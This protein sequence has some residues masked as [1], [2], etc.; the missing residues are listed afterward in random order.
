[1]S[2]LFHPERPGGK[3]GP[4]SLSLND[5]LLPLFFSLLTATSLTL[6]L[7]ALTYEPAVVICMYTYITVPI[8]LQVLV[9]Q[10]V[11]IAICPNRGYHKTFSY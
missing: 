11:L 4:R 2:C 1:M 8:L 3:K 5:H 6:A 7:W 9:F 10:R